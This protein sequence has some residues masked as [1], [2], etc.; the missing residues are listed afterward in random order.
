MKILS[1]VS[2]LAISLTA[3]SE[4]SVAA[5]KNTAQ[6]SVIETASTTVPSNSLIVAELFTSQGCSS[7]PP[8][9]RLFSTLADRD[10]VL[11]L[12][13]HVDIWDD[14]VH[15]GSRWK[16]PYSSDAFTGRQRSYNRSIRQTG[17]IYTPQAVVNGQLEGVGSRSGEVTAM[18]E[19]ASVLPIGVQIK[20]DKI[21]I[22]SS[23]QSADILFL[24]L[25][26]KHETDIKGGE[27]KGRKLA[28]KNIVLDATVLGQTGDKPKEFNL[29]SIGN[30]ETCAV[31]IQT[32]NGNVGPV[33]GAAKCL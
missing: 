21:S 8:A 3:C 10:D 14:L 11:T 2:L 5:E 28:G 20:N 32:F 22:A 24:R 27:N 1:F 9:E 33:L 6:S 18:L 31:L 16:D 25:L 17:S 19:N 26:K 12:E 30:G 7:C 29:P 23:S 15:G 4:V 13:W